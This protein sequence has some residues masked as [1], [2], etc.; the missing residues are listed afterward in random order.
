MDDLFPAS[1]PPA[2]PPP[3]DTPP[4][5]PNQDSLVAK[6][7]ENVTNAL[8]RTLERVESLENRVQPPTK[9]PEQDPPAQRFDKADFTDFYNDPDGFIQ[10]R[11][12]ERL[13]GFAEQLTPI[14]G[15]ALDGATATAISHSKSNFESQFGTGSW[16]DLISRDLGVALAKL[17]PAQRAKPQYVQALVAG[18][19]GAKM[20]TE[21]GKTQIRDTMKKAADAKRPPAPTVLTGNRIA[22]APDKL[23][24]DE[25][26]VVGKLSK[27]G[28]KV[29]EKSYLESR[30]RG[31][32]EEDWGLD[33]ASK[34]A[35]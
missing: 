7:L 3:T 4:A 30:N 33:W 27:A 21:E 2:D 25:K 24:D 17:T 1:D 34:N 14:L 35:S 20:F 9:P 31:R 10:K 16:D 26:E 12:E 15:T 19:I 32:T 11:V 13:A 6:T 22:P 23:T 8:G 28:M 29:T 18:L 5:P